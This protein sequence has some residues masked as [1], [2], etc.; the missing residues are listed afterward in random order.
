MVETRIQSLFKLVVPALLL[1]SISILADD[2]LSGLIKDGKYVKAVEHIEKSIPAGQRTVEVWLQYA[3]ALEKSGGDKQKIDKAFVE[4]QKVQPSDPRI[5]AAMGEYYLRSSNCRK[6]IQ[7]LQKWYLLSRN[8]RAAEAMATCAMNLKQYDKARDAAESAVMID[9]NSAEARKVLSFL[10][11][12]EKDWAGA[13][14]QLEYIVA[15]NKDDVTYWKK[16]ARCYEELKNKDRLVVAAARIV[17]LDSKD[18][19]SRGIMVDHY[20][21]KKDNGAA[22]PLLK[23]LAVLTPNDAKVFSHLYRISLESNRK[24]DAILYM[25]NYLIIDST[26]A[27]SYKALGDLLFEQKNSA[28]A[29]DAYRK[30]SKL[31]PAI[32]GV[33]RNYLSLVLEKKL[34]NEA[35]AVMPRA[36][37]AGEV[38]AQTYA[39]VGMIFKKRK[40]CSQAIGYFQSALKI[41]AKNLTVLSALAECQASTGKK[42]EALLNYRQVVMLNPSANTEYRELATLLAAQNKTDEAMENYRKYLEKSPADEN[43][44]SIVGLY[45]HK[46]K[47]CKEALFYLEKVTSAKYMTLPLLMKTGDCYFQSGNYT[48]TIEYLAKARAKNPS[49]ASLA[50]ILKPLA[51]SY[52]KTGALVNAAKTYEAY[53]QLPGI[54]DADASFNQAFLRENTDKAGAIPL[55]LANIK[56]YPKDARSFTRLGILLSD[57]KNQRAKAISYLEKAASLAADDTLVL[58]KLCDV[59]H[60]AGSRTKELATAMKLVTIQPDNLTANRRAGTINYKK[61]QFAPAVPYLEKVFAA[62]PKD[63]EIALMLADAYSR[64]KNPD[65]AMDIYSK[66]V[67]L[68]PDNVPVWLSLIAAAEAAGKKENEAQ[69]RKKLAS[70]DRKAVSKNAKAVEPRLRLAEY[71]YSRN[72][73]EGAFS[74]YKDLAELTPK[75][76]LVISR[77]L[78]ISRKKGKNNDA[79]SYLK[80]YVALDGKNA[81]AHLELGTMLHEQKNSDGALAEYRTALKLDSSL[82]GFLRAYAEIVIAKNLDDEAV[83]VLNL[84]I[85]RNETEAKFYPVL[86]KIYQKKKLYPQAIAMFKKASTDDPKNLQVLASLGECQAANNDISGAVISLE[87]VV[88]L[89]PKA[90]KEYKTLGSLQMRQKKKEEAV[91]SYRKYLETAGEDDT[92]AKTVGLYLYNQKLFPDAIFYL[93]KVKSEAL[94]DPEYLLSL[95]DAYYQTKN[96]AKVCDIYSRLFTKKASESTLKKILRPLGECYEKTN[97]PD[98]AADAY[99]AY[100]ALPGIKDADASYLRALL[101]EKSSPKTAES[102]YI[103]NTKSFPKD[104]R[105]FIR[106]GLMYAENPQTLGKAAEMLSQA[107]LLVPKDASLLLKL[108]EVWKALKNENKELET[109]KN[110]LVLEPQNVEVNKRAGTLFISKKMYQKAVECLEVVHVTSPGNTEIM[111]LL[112]D[113]YLKTNRKDNALELLSKVHSKQKHDTDLMLQLY[114]LYREVGKNTEA[115]NMIKQLITL[116][117]ENKYRLMYAANLLEQKRYEEVALIS[118]EIIK[119][120]P[121]NLEGLMLLGKAQSYLKKYDDAAESFKMASYVKEDYAPAYYERGEVYRK[122]KSFE[123]AESYYSKALHHDQKYGLAELGIARCAKAQNKRDEYLAHLKKAKLLDSENREI[124]AEEKEATPKK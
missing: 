53:V 48:K 68:Q 20:L 55:Y 78:N 86:G 87:Q 10:Y 27:D 19:R 90:G 121:M 23:E 100:T 2:R 22:L 104:G 1:L 4:A 65:K 115:E 96:C 81:K 13:A 95:G 54:D 94:F 51:V 31:N 98:R 12:N 64:S 39:S 92:V 74:V 82:T 57:D 28:E 17:S 37:A 109:Y 24:K 3:E 41:D 108:A 114:T 117:K 36:V 60:A 111:L 88:L 91:K 119:D 76:T 38:D 89:N 112:A 80:Q 8:A 118:S 106:L 33:F 67:E 110:L 52:E 45:F 61:K 71:L 34:D 30:A 73:L 70:I 62:A 75:D 58:Q 120:E 59:Y 16:L 84:A 97:N 85:K 105:S 5:F 35:I 7:Y 11:F 69:Y 93:E 63:T 83:T 50:E 79:L 47:Q 124:L 72:D 101:K 9:S 102:F 32:T 21:E 44:A 103:A 49:P 56:K 29:L 46:K 122:Q 25:R 42:A 26:N 18:V 77:L 99:A 15:R 40:Q 113:A 66:V 14:Q 107:S 116:K 6:A 123:R 43:V